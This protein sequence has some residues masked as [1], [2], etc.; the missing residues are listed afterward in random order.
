MPQSVEF[1]S[2]YVAEAKSLGIRTK[3]YYTIRE[4]SNRVAELWALLSLQGEIY[5]DLPNSPWTVPQKGYNHEWDAHGGDVW[6]HQHVAEGYT[7]CWQNPLAN[8]DMDGAMC[9]IGTSRWFN[10][11]LEG[12]YWSVRHSPHIEG[13][14]YDGIN[15]D[16]KSMRRLRKVIDRAAHEAGIEPPL[17]DFHTGQV[18]TSSSAVSF[19]SHFPYADSAWNG[20]GFG[21]IFGGDA[22]GWLINFSGFQHGI[23]VDMLGSGSEYKAMLF[24]ASHRNAE[25][26]PALWALWDDFKLQDPAVTMIGWWEDDEVA[27]AA[28]VVLPPPPP[29]PPPPPVPSPASDWTAYPNMSFSGPN[30]TPCLCKVS[31]PGDAKDCVC[32]LCCPMHG[33]SVL[34]ISLTA[35]EAACLG[36]GAA[37]EHTAG[38]SCTAVNYDPIYKGCV[39]RA[40]GD[41]HHGAPATQPWAGG[42]GYAY[43]PKQTNVQATADNTQ[44]D[45]AEALVTVFS[46]HKDR[47]MF[48]IAS[49]AKTP[50][51]ITLNVDWASL[52]L[53]PGSSLK[54]SPN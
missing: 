36:Q 33:M 46:V 37:T 11:Y 29:P 24:G 8:G 53:M 39:F 9:D 27:T 14:Y 6:L 42:T 31:S 12:L 45:L 44:A 1:F 22:D 54:V 5:L 13:V 35:C 20:E 23:G 17:L 38:K 18:Q 41:G 51:N 52:G 3:F 50:A 28:V 47:A 26:T 48:V 19:L 7:P 2:A 34:N 49:W 30:V 15:F 32:K 43:M 10:Y 21:S 25:D 40:M 4:L 16:R